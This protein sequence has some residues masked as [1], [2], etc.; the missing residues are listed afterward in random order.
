MKV[1]LNPQSLF[2]LL[3]V[4]IIS[5]ISLTYVSNQAKPEYNDWRR[6]FLLIL[7]IIITVYS[8]GSLSIKI[9]LLSRNN[10]KWIDLIIPITFNILTI[11][12]GSIIV[13]YARLSTDDWDQKHS[14]KSWEK[15]TIQTLSIVVIV[16]IVIMFSLYLIANSRGNKEIIFSIKGLTPVQQDAITL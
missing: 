10:I 6:T 1:Y 16:F 13:D 9:Y 12:L 4:L 15:D 8:V 11:S 14:E 7:G 2:V 5:I 3:L